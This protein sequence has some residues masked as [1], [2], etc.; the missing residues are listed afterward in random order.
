MILATGVAV[1]NTG[2][3]PPKELRGHDLEIMTV[4]RRA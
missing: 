2:A 4:Q 3:K 1:V